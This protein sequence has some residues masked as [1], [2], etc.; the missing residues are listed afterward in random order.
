MCVSTVYL[1]YVGMMPGSPRRNEA[2]MQRSDAQCEASECLSR[3]YPCQY[4]CKYEVARTPVHHP[5]MRVLM[6]RIE[7]SSSGARSREGTTHRNR[8]DVSRSPERPAVPLC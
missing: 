3:R 5:R 1:S 8:C 4:V 6:L 7:W 2:P